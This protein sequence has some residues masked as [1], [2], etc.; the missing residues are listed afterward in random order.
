MS[1]KR[2]V[3]VTP[4]F[5]ANEEDSTC[6]P[7][8]QEYIL[9]VKK[10]YPLLEVI[11][12]T[13]Q[14]PN[15]SKPYYWNGVEVFPC[16][17]SIGKIG[18]WGKAYT[19][20]KKWVTPESIVHSFW[21]SEAS[22]VVA[23][24]SWFKP[25]RWISTA[26]GQDV[27]KSNK[28]LR[29]LNLKKS[30]VVVLSERSKIALKK[31]ISNE[32]ETVPFG[33]SL[34]PMDI[35]ERSIDV[36]GVGSL[37]PLKQWDLFFKIIKEITIANPN[38]SVKIVGDGKL[39]SE[40]NQQLKDLSLEQN[41]K[42]IGEKSRSEVLDL[43]NQSKVLLHTSATES[44]GYVFN[45][46]AQMGCFLVSTPVGIA[47][48]SSFWFVSENPVDMAKKI[49]SVL[50]NRIDFEGRMITSIEETVQQYMRLYDK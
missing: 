35:Q 21:L 14:Y 37:I 1:I 26:M 45:E 30:K 13:L 7:T 5:A 41:I 43:M 40:L 34:K 38:L 15:S 22:L 3:I 33:L 20:L 36:L 46:A 16:H 12:I 6:I 42:L 27:Y 28:Y 32:I 9:Q 44:Q 48:N 31:R 24:Y 23:F 47:E 18:K 19:L 4:G 39:R 29:L 25:V 11:V 50:E 8:L 17:S 49:K 2:I 10:S